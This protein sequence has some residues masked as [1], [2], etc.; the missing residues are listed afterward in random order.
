MRNAVDRE[1]ESRQRGAIEARAEVPEFDP[2]PCPPQPAR[3]RLEV[4]FVFHVHGRVREI[5][6]DHEV[7]RQHGIAADEEVLPAGQCGR[8]PR[9]E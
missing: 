7:A 6:V 4:V 5:R 2:V 8:A 1:V 3:Y 9:A